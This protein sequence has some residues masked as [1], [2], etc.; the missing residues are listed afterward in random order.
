MACHEEYRPPPPHTLRRLPRGSLQRRRR[1]ASRP[2]LLCGRTR[3]RHAGSHLCRRGQGL[4][5]PSGNTGRF[6]V[7]LAARHHALPRQAAGP[8]RADGT[9]DA[10][11]VPPLA[12][13]VLRYHRKHG[14]C[15][16]AGK[17]RYHRL[18][19]RRTAMEKLCGKPCHRRRRSFRSVRSLADNAIAP[20]AWRPSGC[21]RCA[22][23]SWRR[24]PVPPSCT[25]GRSGPAARFSGRSASAFHSAS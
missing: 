25:C 8:A 6:L 13:P 1:Q 23:A 14:Q 5:C 20:R 22:S 3:R 11:H 15:G 16:P 21:G 12:D 17:G 2:H 10:L 4:G 24:R 9:P 18:E 19:Y 7:R